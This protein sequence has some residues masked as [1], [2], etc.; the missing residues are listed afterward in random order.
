MRIN[1]INN[2][3]INP[4]YKAKLDIIG[5]KKL[6]NVEQLKTLT[7]KAAKIGNSDEMITLGITRRP[8]IKPVL[9]F[10]SIK[11]G[12]KRIPEQVGSFTL[13]TGF[14]HTFFDVIEPPSFPNKI[15]EV[16]GHREERAQKSFD[17]M[18]KFLDNIKI[19]I[20]KIK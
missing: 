6:L 11:K 9:K 19:G 16:K 4:T 15:I 18:D 8:I 12:F 1:S 13:I 14:C 10:I 2:N 20:E 7:E 5:D 17:I 3:T